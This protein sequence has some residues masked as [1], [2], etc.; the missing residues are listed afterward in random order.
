MDLSGLVGGGA[1]VRRLRPQGQRPARS[2]PSEKL[3]QGH[4]YPLLFSLRILQVSGQGSAEVE[5]DQTLFGNKSFY[6]KMSPLTF[7]T[8]YFIF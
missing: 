8:N 6:S 4:M 2:G 7:H 5:E 1:G 3:V